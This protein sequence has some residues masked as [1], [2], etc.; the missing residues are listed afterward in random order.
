VLDTT[1]T[2]ADGRTVGYAVWGPPQAPAVFYCHGYPGNRHELALAQ[3]ILERHGV[4]AQVVALD[5][6]GYGA[7]T[8]QRHRTFLDWPRDLAEAADRL[9]IDRFAI[10]GA[11]GGCPYALAGGYVLGDRVT[12]LG[13]VAGGAPL[14]DSAMAGAAQRRWPSR[15]RLV[16][17]LQF[18]MIARAFEAGR[19]DAVMDRVVASLGAADRRALQQPEIRRWYTDTTRE[20]FVQGGRG[21]AYEG[22]MYWAPW[23]F[24]VR[25]IL[26]ETFLW[27]G[28]ADGNVPVSAGR[29]LAERL[30]NASYQVWPEHGHF[31]WALGDEVAEVVRTIAGVEEVAQ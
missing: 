11:S 4:V 22:A 5:R 15:N 27:Y 6:P 17:R 3:P 24:E 23:G 29:W 20:C 31:T 10:L 7:S 19:Q 25:G 26:T 14:G 1:L 16:R 8:Y 28:G 30:P 21:A 2:F 13:I 9:G 12:R 18:E